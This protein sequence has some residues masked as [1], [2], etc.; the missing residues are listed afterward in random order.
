[1]GDS[2]EIFV[3][4]A[5]ALAERFVTDFT[6]EG[7]RALADHRV[8]SIA[9]SGGSVATTLFPSLARAP[10]DWSRAD[11]FWADE[12]IVPFADPESNY[13]VALSLLLGPAGISAERIHR[14]PV[15]DA[16]V[17]KAAAAYSSELLRVAGNP[18]RLDFVLLGVGP[19]GHVASLFPHDRT[20]YDQQPV[21]IVDGAPK[22]PRRRM[23]LTMPVL[24]GADRI[25]V[26]AFGESK[27]QALHDAL[28][29][30]DSATPLAMV[31]RE[32]AR[33]LMLI[34]PEAASGI[35]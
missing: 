13:G 6:T 3:A 30:P 19:D 5:N 22:E 4:D 9:L 24:R 32:K 27:R 7:R 14:M 18:P 35:F 20:L 34:D 29:R 2:P 26:A 21:A 16:D 23:T 28:S 12:R 31:V 15:E 25:V 1:M 8:F 33:V 10:F 11:I 17:R